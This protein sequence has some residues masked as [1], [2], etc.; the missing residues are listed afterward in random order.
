VVHR[1]L[2]RGAQSQV[3][4]VYDRLLDTRRALK[5]ATSSRHLR[6]FRTEYRRLAELRHPNIVRVYD[7]GVTPNAL[8]YYTM[9]LVQGAALSHFAERR[10]VPVL[11]LLALQ[12]LDA[13]ATLHARGWVHRDIKPTNL[14]VVGRGRSA[15]LRLIDLGLLAGVGRP[16][17]AAGTL[18]YMAP[19]VARGERVDGRADL[20]SLGL[21]LYELLLPASAP[22]TIE[23]V[24]VRMRERLVPPRAST[25]PSPRR[26]LRLS[27]ASSSPTCSHAPRCAGSGR[28]SRRGPGR[29]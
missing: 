13:L 3:F 2:G 17:R 6:R 16:T 27:C 11:G 14:L 18:T 22:R 21:V 23:Q 8:P 20:F 19:E 25:R 28:D 10:D 5:L 12:A 1:E 7:F 9:E 26:F 24:S 29:P 15:L 4:E